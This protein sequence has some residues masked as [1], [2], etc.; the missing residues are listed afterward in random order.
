MFME[1][2]FHSFF[3][4]NLL[5]FEVSTKVVKLHLIN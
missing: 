1:L 5:I 4:C 3:N 2:Y